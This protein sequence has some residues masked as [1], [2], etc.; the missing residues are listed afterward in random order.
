MAEETL[1]LERSAP[2]FAGAYQRLVDRLVGACAGKTA[3]RT[4]DIFPE[5][6]LPD[7]H[8]RLT[9]FDD[10][11]VGT[12][13]VVSLNRGQWCSYCR[14][15]L[16]GLQEIHAEI[17]R[18]GAN[19]VAITPDREEYAM[20]L[21]ASCRLAFPL[22][23]DVGNGFALSLGLAVWCG[24]EVRDLYRNSG[25]ALNVY[26]G[27]EGWLI[28]IP[29]TYVVAPDRRIKACFVDPDFRQRISPED[30]LKAI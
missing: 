6:L 26:Q 28:P 22:L 1:R 19:V 25:I 7:D 5:F 29:A 13:L 2:E 15:E 16:E 11:S 27:D 3:P 4:G 21:R 8:G 30:I 10:L 14:I 17:M 24:D 20:R 23:S 12:T 18:R 9:G